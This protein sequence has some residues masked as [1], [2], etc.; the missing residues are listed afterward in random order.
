MSQ[1]LDPRSD[2][3]SE[4]A[5]QSEPSSVEIL[6]RCLPHFGGLGPDQALA[7]VNTR[8][9]RLSAEPVERLSTYEAVVA[10]AVAEALLSRADGLE[11]IRRA[12]SRQPGANA[13]LERALALREALYE[14][15][16]DRVRERPA[17]RRA[18]ATLNREFRAAGAHRRVELSA[19][20]RAIAWL[21]DTDLERPLWPIAY[22]SAMFLVGQEAPI[23]EC[24][25]R[26]CGWLFV[27]RS[28]N[29]TRQWCYMNVCGNREKARRHYE[30]TRQHPA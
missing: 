5:A 29:H 4:P 20:I 7:F 30:R 2:R 15:L 14:V 24:A 21:V 13:V 22:D 19:D 25:G 23:R 27:D 11:V 18:L 17:D 1:L 6:D 3:I 28:P 12:A 8:S 10:Y 9:W 16:I 26:G